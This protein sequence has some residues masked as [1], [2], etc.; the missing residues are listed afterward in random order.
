MKPDTFNKTSSSKLLYFFSEA[1]ENEITITFLIILFTF[2]ISC[3]EMNFLSHC[4][5]LSWQNYKMGM[6][7]NT[8]GMEEGTL[9]I[10]MGKLLALN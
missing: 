8:N 9:E 7:E 2:G 4:G 6:A 3:P 5:V 1:V 10:G